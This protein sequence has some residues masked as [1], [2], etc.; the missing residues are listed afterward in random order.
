MSATAQTLPPPAAV[1]AETPV[2]PL[3]VIIADAS[4]L[5]RE[6]LR[7]AVLMAEPHASIEI[8]DD[9]RDTESALL[10]SRF[11]L[12]FI[13]MRLP[14]GGADTVSRVKA[15][16]CPSL[17]AMTVP[18][19]GP[20]SI[21]AGRK[22]G[23]FEV[24]CKPVEEAE[25]AALIRTLRRMTQPMTALIVSQSEAT[26]EVVYS[27]LETA[28][29]SFDILEAEDWVGMQKAL[30]SG[31]VD[32][33]M[34]DFDV[35]KIDALELLC[36]AQ[37]SHPQTP[38]LMMQALDQPTRAQAARYFGAKAV[39]KKPFFAPDLDR[40]LFDAWSLAYPAIGYNPL[41]KAAHRAA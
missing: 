1:I 23:A 38:V 9:A 30:T 15:A 6:R 17:L 11:D 27:M 25:I 13:D 32:L 20:S 14:G 4:E 34:L 35:K 33:M 31:S 5:A 26:R 37:N 3:R 16:G 28:R 19:V 40:A 29:F 41:A 8:S 12:A 10:S 21:D 2:R 36:R 22:A 24:L 39:L 7:S 18:L